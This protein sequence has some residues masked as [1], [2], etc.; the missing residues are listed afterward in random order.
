[1]KESR[2]DQI[3]LDAFRGIT[4]IATGRAATSLSN[5]L[6]RKV[7]ITVPNVTTEAIEQVPEL[8]GGREES[9]VVVHFAIS[10]QV[11]GSIILVLSSSEALRFASLL[12]GQEFADMES[13]DE[14][15]LSALREL[16][17]IVTGSYVRVL[18]EGLQV[19]ITYSVPG[20]AYDMLGAI[21][22]ETLA[23]LSL[24]TESVVV[25]ESEFI[26]SEQIYRSH[27]VFI[28]SPNTVSTIIRAL[29]SWEEST[30][31]MIGSDNVKH[32]Q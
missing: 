10:G 7:S 2:F 32:N 24:E 20:F 16:G 11:S 19:K 23:R 26:V 13:L 22:D 5:L 30:P 6:R 4:S 17:N 31:S 28:L 29:G 9:L 27:L 15:G 3:R 1:M 25:M 21:L 12:T 14:M 18:A 8:L